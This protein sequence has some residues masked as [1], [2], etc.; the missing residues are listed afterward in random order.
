MKNKLI[1]NSLYRDDFV[2]LGI[3]SNSATDKTTKKME[4]LKLQKELNSIAKLTMITGTL[5]I[6]V[7]L[8]AENGLEL[9]EKCDAVLNNLIVPAGLEIEENLV[10]R[11]DLKIYISFRK[12][13]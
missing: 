4:N 6:L 12:I 1:K 7:D 3:G 8:K 9:N 13:N 10:Y 11:R 2:I 5:F